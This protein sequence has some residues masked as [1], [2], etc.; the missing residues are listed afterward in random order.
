MIREIDE[1]DDQ[2]GEQYWGT[3]RLK[4]MIDSRG[5]ER[6]R[7]ALTL[8]KSLQFDSSRQIRVAD[9]GCGIGRRYINFTEVFDKEF[10]YFGF[11]REQIMIDNAERYF[12]HQKFVKCELQELTD[13]HP[14]FIGYFD[15]A[16]TFHVLEYNH[17]LQQDEMIK[18][19]YKILRSKGYYYM[20]ENTIYEHNNIGYESLDDIRSL[21][22]HS[23]TEAGWIRKL[24]RLG[25]ELVTKTGKDGNFIFRKL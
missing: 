2:K 5:L 16:F 1:W 14:G 18:N 6:E 15:L 7:G 8:L 19:F 4:R 3:D 9:L 17:V 11:D 25:F 22:N 24:R 13:V 12:R 23:Y 21:N 20:I 10:E